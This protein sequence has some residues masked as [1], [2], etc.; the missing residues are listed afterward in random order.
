MT[1]KKLSEWSPHPSSNLTLATLILVVLGII[2]NYKNQERR[3][4]N[5]LMVDTWMYLKQFFEM[6]S[7]S[8]ICFSCFFEFGELFKGKCQKTVKRLPQATLKEFLHLIVILSFISFQVLPTFFFL[9]YFL[10]E[11]VGSH[12]LRTAT[13]KTV[14][15][16]KISCLCRL[17]NRITLW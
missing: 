6:K 15:G 13:V 17:A 7:Y 16:L 12:W 10:V 2:R 3:G 4:N 11:E 14:S 9:I 1:F 5:L 8:T